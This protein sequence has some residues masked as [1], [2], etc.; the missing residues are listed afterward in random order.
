MRGNR[1]FFFQI[2][3]A[4]VRRKNLHGNDG[5]FTNDRLGRLGTQHYGDVRNPEARLLYLYA[6]LHPGPDALL[7]V[8]SQIMR[9]GGL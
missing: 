7:V 9:D 2:A 6:N 4:I 1:D 8:R 5:S 3:S